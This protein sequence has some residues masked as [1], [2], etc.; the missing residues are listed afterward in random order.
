MET[1]SEAP[2]NLKHR[3][4]GAVI[5]VSVPVLLLPWLLGGQNGHQAID[6]A[7]LILE[8]KS[9]FFLSEMLRINGTPG[10]SV[11]NYG[12]YIMLR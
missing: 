11:R 1:T 3:A 5:L 4:T 6:E 12:L 8:P 10:G 9:E 2:F 7:S